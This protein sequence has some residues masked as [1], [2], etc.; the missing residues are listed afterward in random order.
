MIPIEEDDKD[1]D[2]QLPAAGFVDDEGAFEVCRDDYN[3]NIC[4]R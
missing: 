4:L 1:P 2:Y 3:D